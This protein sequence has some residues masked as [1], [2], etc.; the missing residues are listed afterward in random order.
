MI[1]HC[2]I[3]VAHFEKEEDE[4]LDADFEAWA[5]RKEYEE[6]LVMGGAIA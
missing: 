6:A 2:E 5:D 4:A 1:L 3:L